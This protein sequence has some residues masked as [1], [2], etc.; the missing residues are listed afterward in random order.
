MGTWRLLLA[1]QAHTQQKQK[2]RHKLSHQ[3]G[4]RLRDAPLIMDFG[5]ATTSNPE[6]NYDFHN[7]LMQGMLSFLLFAGSF[8]VDASS[9]RKEK[10][11]IFILSF[12]GTIF[13]MILISHSPVKFQRKFPVIFPV[14]LAELLLSLLYSS[15]PRRSAGGVCN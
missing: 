10:T 9:M 3:D 7:I 1:L 12:C 14:I 13:S 2:K 15:A 8:G 6:N 11:M 4:T 5:R